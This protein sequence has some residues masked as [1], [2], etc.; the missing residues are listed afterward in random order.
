MIGLE[1]FLAAALQRQG[2]GET[3]LEIEQSDPIRRDCDA[4]HRRNHLA[5]LSAPGLGLS[6][7]EVAVGSGD[8]FGDNAIDR[9]EPGCAAKE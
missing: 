7:V 3:S 8:I 9:I 2:A 6:G 1:N 4:N 5:E